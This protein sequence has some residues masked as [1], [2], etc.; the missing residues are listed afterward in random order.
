MIKEKILSRSVRLMFTGGLIL[1]AQ[2]AAAQDVEKVQKV[3]VTGTRIPTINVDGPSPVTVLSAKDIKIDGARSVEDLLNN[4]PQVF[5][6]QGGAVSNGA[7]GTSTVSLRGLGADRT[8]VLVNGRRLP[9]GSVNST[10]ADLNEVPAG[11][12]KRVDV[13]TGGAGA[14]YGAGAVAGVVNFI[15]KDNY[16][17]VEL[18]V[19][20]SGN[21]H[22]QHN[23]V[24]AVVSGRGFPVPGSIGYDGK[25]QDASI[26]MGS[27]FADGKGNATLYFTYKKT[28][29]LL[30]S[31]RDFSSCA[32]GSSAAGFSCSG[33]GTPTGGRVGLQSGGGSFTNADGNGTARKYVSKTDAYNFGPL[34]YLQRPSEIYGFNAQAHFDINDQVRVYEE[35]NFHTYNTD[36]QVAPGGVFYGQQATLSYDNPLLSS[37][38]KSALGLNNPGDTAAVFVGKRNVEGG[39]RISSITDTS[40]RNVL[41]VKGDVG[42]WHYDA[43]AQISRVNHQESENN[44]FST[45]RIANALDVV[46]VNGQ[47]VCRSVVNGSDP[48]CV[49]YNMFKLGGV[50]QAALN[51]LQVT[52]LKTGYTQQTVLGANIGSDLSAYGIKSPW[53]SSGIGV[54]FGTEQRAEKLVYTPDLENSTG[55]LAGS[56]GPSPAVAGS[57]SVKEAFGEVHIPIAEKLPFIESLDLSTSYRYSDYSTNKTTNTYGLGLEWSPIKQL[58][59]RGSYQVAVRAPTIFDLY[60]QQ[61]VGLNGPSDDPCSG[62]TPSASAAQCAKTGVTAAQYGNVTNNS[63][64][65]YQSLTGGNQNVNPEKAKTYTLGFVVEPVKNLS[66]TVD[67]FNIKI[68]N[69]ISTVDP[70]TALNQCLQTG[71]PVFCNLVHRDKFGSLWLSTDGYILANTTNI[72]KV[73]TSGIDVGGS[74]SFKLNTLGS[75]N[76]GF[77]GT[78]LSKLTTENVPGLGAYDCKGYFG[79]TCGTP[80]PEWRHKFRT[81]WATPWKVE[82]S[83]TWRH[84]SSVNNDTLNPSPLLAGTVNP[85][86]AT[87]GARDYFDLYAAYPITKTITISGGINN[88]F[89]KDPPIA[90][91]NATAAAGSA[92]GNTYP[93]VYDSYGRKL[94]INLT[95]K[96]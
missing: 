37:S 62:T 51:Y 94:F 44:Y 87:L 61:A 22:S 64:N 43:F 50:N 91:T 6:D 45:T 93:Q 53:S 3:E 67:A 60:N 18:Q 29:A 30:Q 1:G 65:Q 36:A 69:T 21:N 89:D 72:G 33:S 77:N 59:L 14:V 55:D 70:T 7:T 78:Y 56:G 39:P 17:G 15:L 20:S 35:F 85:I 68:D 13:L 12:I 8:L 16:E 41:G 42:N 32:L 9:S 88:L 10:A 76:F 66:I 90:S 48:T 63:A 86:E 27:N 95:A 34:N 28:D 80:N 4:L 92:N 2:L 47:A 57:Y 84:F 5:A 49:P 74:Y 79:A 58:R 23:D 75:L 25:V 73:T 26:L 54:S 24:G 83:G 82:V 96:F 19:N 11:L 31:Q 81:T 40:Y 52:G 38:W 71:N 46:N